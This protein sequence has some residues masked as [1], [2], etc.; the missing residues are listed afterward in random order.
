MLHATANAQNGHHTLTDKSCIVA[1]FAVFI[2]TTHGKTRYD[3]AD[4]GS[5]ALM[6]T[7]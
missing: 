4:E 6:M 5:M 1:F 3:G 2:S 7:D